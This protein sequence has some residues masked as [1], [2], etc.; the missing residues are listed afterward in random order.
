MDTEKTGEVLDVVSETQ[1]QSESS[2]EKVV[3]SNLETSE[4]STEPEK[5]SAT[6]EETEQL[7]VNG[8][9]AELL[10]MND[11]DDSPEIV[12]GS[13]KPSEEKPKMTTMDLPEQNE[14]PDESLEKAQESKETE[15]LPAA[16]EQPQMGGSTEKVSDPATALN[17]EPENILLE[18]QQ[19][20]PENSPEHVPLHEP[21]AESPSEPEPEKLVESA[22][23]AELPEP[24]LPDPDKLPELLDEEQPN[25]ADRVPEKV[26]IKAEA[27][28]DTQPEEADKVVE[29]KEMPSQPTK[30]MEEKKLAETEPAGVGK[31]A[32]TELEEELGAEKPME[33]EIKSPGA[34]NIKAADAGKVE[35]EK[36]VDAGTM[37]AEEEREGASGPKEGEVQK[38]PEK[39]PA[40]GTL[41]FPLLEQEQTKAALRA[42]RTLVV[43]RG[44]PGSGKTIL[45]QAIAESYQDLSSVFSAD[46][47]GVKPE[48]PEASADGY[49]ALDKAVVDCC[50]AGTASSLLIV[51]D[52]TNHTQERLACLGEIA[53]QQRLVAIFLEPHTE[54]S[55]DLSQLANRTGRGLK[56]SQI[57]AMKDPFEE[58]SLPL[59]F[60]WFLFP[61]VQEKVRCTSM[62]FLKTL[63]TLDAFKKH[64]TDFTGETEKEVDLEQY[65]QAK[66]SLHC[67][68]KFCDYGKAEGAKEYAEISAVKELY[69][70]VFELSLTALF[71]TPRTVGARVSL[72]EEQL[73]LWPADAEKEAEAAIPK[74]ASLPPGSRA[75]IT[76][77][78]AEGVEPVQTG[79]DLL[80]ILALEQQGEVLEEM[81]LGS[82]SYYGSGRWLLSL[83]E[84]ISV[85]ACF[86]SFYGP[87]KVDQTKKEAEK[88]KKPKCTIL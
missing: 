33:A 80:D 43:L 39:I 40:P 51:V 46:E 14:L 5:S 1:Q 68:T 73:V 84:P 53:E 75:H 65:F 67:T 13:V 82:L 24:T 3:V 45:A 57:Q 56:E 76:L 47:Y 36:S 54:W 16:T 87:K 12:T 62:D 64:L 26:E 77:G 69:S 10:F 37:K 42:S 9:D 30:E 8:H 29:E 60:G 32:P 49:K 44:L 38:E 83:R 55:R 78:C 41:S 79:L 81:E 19:P 61:T 17:T 27:V 2:V 21:L 74:A 58:T 63:D 72:S 86:S 6:V 22:P 48:N 35:P 34:L 70:S 15:K 59:Y 66:G 50:S 31:K 88:K 71:V 20:E 52:D 23:E 28:M 18:Q 85:N 7:A 11:K 4:K 25:Q